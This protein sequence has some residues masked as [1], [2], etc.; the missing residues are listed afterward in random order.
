[1]TVDRIK[2]HFQNNDMFVNEAK[3]EERMTFAV[4]LGTILVRTLD[5]MTADPTAK[6]FA[7]ELGSGET[8][9]EILVRRK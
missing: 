5:K 4:N 2:K 3:A 8:A 1:M 6:E 7:F 9:F